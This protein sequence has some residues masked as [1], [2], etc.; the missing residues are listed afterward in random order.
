[1]AVKGKAMN[2]TFLCL[3]TLLLFAAGTFAD[4]QQT[5]R[6][7]RIGFLAAGFPSTHSTYIEA[8]RQGLRDLGY[9]EDQNILIEYRYAEGKF[10]RLPDLAAELVRLKVDVIVPGGGIQAIRP[11]KNVTTTIPIVMTG[12]AEPVA[13]GFV[14]SLAR[15][16][17]NITGLSL[18][19]AELSGKRLELLKEAVPSVS[20]V[21]VFSYLSDPG[22]LSL[23][24]MLAAAQTLGLKL[25][26]VEVR[27]PNDF[28]RAFQGVVKARAGALTVGT[29]P[30]FNANRKRIIDL[31]AKNRLCLERLRG[32]WRSDVL[33][34]EPA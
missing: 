26:S 6:V 1:M 19:G 23:K 15:P 22:D 32:G 21:A 2:R 27:G 30:L 7:P 14:V 17:G 34:D 5:K 25:Q 10:D 33:R 31:A 18:G 28:E 3:L 16:G 13:S 20:R 24:E 8:F 4:A 29:A 12:T 9:V 11:A